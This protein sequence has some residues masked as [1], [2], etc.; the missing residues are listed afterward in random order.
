DLGRMGVGDV[1]VWGRGVDVSRFSPERRGG[2]VRGI[3]HD[4]DSFTLLH[5]GRLAAEKDVDRVLEGFELARKGWRHSSRWIRLVVA[6]RGPR[7]EQLRAAAGP[8]V[9]FLGNLDRDTEL[10]VLYAN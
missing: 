7:E 2:E 1:E 6:G 10:P 9:T 3:H 4:P 5:V 8:R